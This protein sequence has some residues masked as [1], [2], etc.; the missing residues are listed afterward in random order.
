MRETCWES[1]LG[2][3]VGTAGPVAFKDFEGR[4]VR[5]RGGEMCADIVSVGRLV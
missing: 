4:M 2:D 3:S 1:Q 5:L